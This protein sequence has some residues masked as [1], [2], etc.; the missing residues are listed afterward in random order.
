MRYIHEAK[1]VIIVNFSCIQM[2]GLALIVIVSDNRLF[3][4]RYVKT[5]AEI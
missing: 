4:C 5:I 3:L 1:R 2:S